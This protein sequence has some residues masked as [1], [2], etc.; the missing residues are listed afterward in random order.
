MI[1][2]SS[3]A[4]LQVPSH[5]RSV[6]PALSTPTEPSRREKRRGSYEYARSHP[7]GVAAA[8]AIP[9]RLSP[10]RRERTGES[11]APSLGLDL[12]P[13]SSEGPLPG[14]CE[15]PE[16]AARTTPVPRRSAGPGTADR[17][18]R[19]PLSPPFPSRP[20]PESAGL[21]LKGRRTGPLRGGVPSR[22]APELGATP[23]PQPNQRTKSASL[24]DVPPG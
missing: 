10:R 15:A 3:S 13:P 8:S 19:P 23:P 16:A 7:T 1:L 11:P 6:A 18:R 22:P 17:G 12:R 2:S 5:R 24:P 9:T 4:R 21:L 20:L 14:R